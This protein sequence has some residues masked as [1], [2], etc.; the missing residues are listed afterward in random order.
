FDDAEAMPFFEKEASRGRLELRVAYYPRHTM[1]DELLRRNIRFGYGDDL[2]RVMGIK[3]FADGALGSQ[4]A[5][6]FHRYTGSKDNY[7]IQVMSTKE[8]VRIIRKAARLGFP[9]A[10]HG[11]GDRA[12]ANIL[13]AFEAARREPTGA[14]HRI[15]HVQLIRRKDIPRLRRLG[16][17]AS[18]Q[19]SHC[20]SD[21][22]MIR[23][24]WGARGRNAFL[25]RTFLETGIPL[26]FGSDAPIEPLDPLSGI[27]D[28]VRRSRRGHRDR[29]YPEQ[30]LT[31]A[32]ALYAFTVGPAIA[33]GQVHNSGFLLPGHLAD[34][35]ILR[36]DITRIAADRLYDTPVLATILDGRLRYCHS[37]L[38][39]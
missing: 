2:F 34:L 27:A 32:E 29:F 5:L 11:I 23:A 9:C 13:D 3:L 26:A 38:R 14:P 16:I 21:I 20:P 15:E 25:F 28:A 39:L 4:S 35:V 10:I 30:R 1:L 22:P 17:V 6:C 31:A 19:P 24:Y 12:V 36:E 7:G 8:M 33:V 37:S 18:M